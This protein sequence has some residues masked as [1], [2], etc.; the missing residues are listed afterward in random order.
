[1]LT[2]VACEKAR[3]KDRDY[4]LADAGGLYLFVTKSGHR[5]WRFKY[6]FGGKER[7]LIF[8]SFP[9]MALKVARD[10]RDAAKR[11]LHE[12]KD[13]ALVQKSAKLVRSTPSAVTFETF[14]RAWHAHE[15]NRWK[16]VHANDVITSLER[17]VFP[18]LGR[19]DVA[20][21]DEQMVIAVLEKVERRG[22]IETAHRLRQRISSVFKYAKAKGVTRFNP[23]VD[24]QIVMKPVPKRK[25]R[26][27]LLEISD[28]QKLIEVVEHAGASPVT[29]AASRF[30]AL[31]A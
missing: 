20:D 28:L 11:L 13:P 25:R 4:K 14:A 15:A 8:G 27:A 3:A 12:G 19:F 2:V 30:L 17:D 21:I 23:S 31:T 5:S 1:M 10:Q 7:R 16:P 29:K 24:V 18:D 26:P 6:R 22:A 9:E